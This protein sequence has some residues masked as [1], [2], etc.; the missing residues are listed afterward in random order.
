MNEILRGDHIVPAIALKDLAIALAMAVFAGAMLPGGVALPG[1]PDDTIQ[2]GLAF[3]TLTATFRMA[4]PGVAWMHHF[5]LMATIGGAMELVQL[6]PA[7]H[8]DA[9]VA[10]WLVDVAASLATLT[11]LGLGRV[12]RLILA[13]R[14]SSLPHTR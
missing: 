6:V 2:H 12:C 10:D 8:R 5:V 7:L 14:L 4:W 1:N 11:G 3:A 9:S 13:R